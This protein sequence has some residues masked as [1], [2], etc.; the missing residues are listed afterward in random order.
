MGS[1]HTASGTLDYWIYSQFLPAL[2]PSDTPDPADYTIGG[3][4]AFGRSIG[5]WSLGTSFLASEIDGDWS[6]LGGLD[7]QWLLGPLELTTE[8]YYQG[9]DIEERNL[10]GI[11][12]QGVYELVPT[13]YLVGRYEHYEPEGSKGADLADLG[14]AWIPKPY[15]HLKASYRLTSRS[16]S[17]FFAPPAEGIRRGLSVAVSVIF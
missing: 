2:D 12:I 1:F 6:F 10:W 11:Y 15:L 17:E 14:V 5:Q 7:A 3:R 4:L 9:G 16:L 13:F 8:L